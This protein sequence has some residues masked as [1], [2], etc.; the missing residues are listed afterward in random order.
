MKRFAKI[1][2]FTALVTGGTI[3]A[4]YADRGIG[5]K[6]GKVK[7]NIV[8]TNNNIKS[9]LSFNLKTGLKYTGTLLPA[10]NA[11]GNASNYLVTFQKGNSVY[12]IPYKHKAISSEI[13]QGYTGLKLVIKP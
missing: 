5:K 4:S 9:N 7:L 2:F 8:N 12:I 1:L 10:T 6:K 13:R 3:W 11:R